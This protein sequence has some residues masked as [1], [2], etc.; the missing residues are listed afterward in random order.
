VPNAR[1]VELSGDFT[2]WKPMAL[3]RAGNDRWEATLP[4][5]PGIHRLAIRVDGDAWTPPPGVN[6]VPDEFQ[7]TVGVIV[8]RD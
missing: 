7:G 8:V 5:T 6:A 2:G 3:T 4:I 1:T